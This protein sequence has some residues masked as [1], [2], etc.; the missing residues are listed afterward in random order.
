MAAKK[1]CP[2]CGSGGVHVD[3]PS[4]YRYEH[5]GLANVILKGQGIVRIFH[6]KECE[7]VTTVIRDERQL[8]QVIGLVLLQRPPGMTG[9][10]LRYLRNLFEMTQAELAKAL[11]LPRRPTVAEWERKHGAIFS[12]PREEITP[13]LVLLHLFKERVT[14]SDHCALLPPH[15]EMYEKVVSSFVE[16]VAGTVLREGKKR[17]P[18]SGI[19][20]RLRGRSKWSSDLV[21]V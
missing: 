14:D 8:L 15:I 6:C 7:N 9:E 20:V 4:E 11:G 17:S 13:R 1:R 18:R 21:P 2:M 10:E 5:S 16:H 19:N 3:S 12:T